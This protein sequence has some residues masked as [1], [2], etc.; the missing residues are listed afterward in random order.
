MSDS[1]VTLWLGVHQAPLSMEFPG[2]D[3]GVPFPAP[4]D[5]P[6]PGTQLLSPNWQEDSLLLNH[7][8]SYISVYISEV[9]SL[10]RVR[11]FATPWSVAYQAPSSMGFS[12]QEYWSGVPFPSE[13]ALI[14]QGV[15]EAFFS[16]LTI[17]RFLYKRF[18]GPQ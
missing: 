6:E 11:F 16:S 17:H 8:G 12:R 10:S 7:Q 3:T 9:K 1:F 18:W 14:L 5:L 15:L 4:G 13:K 2:K